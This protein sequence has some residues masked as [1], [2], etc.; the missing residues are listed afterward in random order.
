LPSESASPKLHDFAIRSSSPYFPGPVSRRDGVSDA[1]SVHRYWTLNRVPGPVRTGPRSRQGD[2]D[3]RKGGR[4]NV[5]LRRTRLGA[6]R[7][8]RRRPTTAGDVSLCWRRDFCACQ[9][10][11]RHLPLPT[12]HTTNPAPHP[13]SPTPHTSLTTTH[14]PAPNPPA[15]SQNVEDDPSC[16][17]LQ[18]QTESEE[19]AGDEAGEEAE[20]RSPPSVPPHA[21][22]PWRG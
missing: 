5:S 11:R 6:G 1:F 22:R 7:N 2:P 16:F 13:R 12:I 14:P 17:C 10:S 19:E 4:P 3:A 18:G 21:T 20:V 9:N 15:H 8:S